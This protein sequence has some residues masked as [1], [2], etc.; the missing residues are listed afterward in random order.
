MTID[1]SWPG[2]AV[3][4]TASLR[5]PMS[6]PSTSCR[7]GRKTWTAAFAGMTRG[8]VGGFHR[9]G[10]ACP[11]HPRLA[12]RKKDVDARH[13]PG[14]TRKDEHRSVMAGPVPAI[15]V[16]ATCK[17]DVDARHSPGMTRKDE[18]RSVM[19]GP[20]PATHVFA[21][22]K[23]DVDARHSPGMTRKDE[24]RSVMAGPVPAIHVFATCKKDVDARHSPGMTRKDEHRSVMAG[25]VPAIHVLPH[26]RKT[27]MP[28][29]RRH[30]ESW[31]Q[32]RIQI[33]PIGIHLVNEA[34][35]PRARPMLDRLLALNRVADIVELLL[36]DEKLEPV[37]LRESVDQPL[38]ML[39]DAS[40]QI[41][42]DTD[43]K[44][45]ATSVGHEVDE[46]AL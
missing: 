20:V 46:A 19:A 29:I 41:A 43:V 3:R 12:A 25:P 32:C 44:Y 4:R 36:V 23:K 21:T 2:I 33:I 22:C 7:Q 45:S 26:A 38:A 14:M 9:H 39:I 30:D 10:R 13:S 37:S 17:K 40:E 16:F 35:F 42:G 11:G 1:P 28:G 8:G 27:W 34:D 6:R 31:R 15:H 24:H 5:S 18:H